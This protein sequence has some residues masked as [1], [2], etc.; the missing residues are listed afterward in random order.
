MLIKKINIK[1]KKNTC[2]NIHFGFFYYL[3][4]HCVNSKRINNKSIIMKTKILSAFG[5]FILM[6]AISLISCKKD[7]KQPAVTD[8]T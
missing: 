7:N 1:P 6:L 3:Y 8:L 2:I 4:L 5:I